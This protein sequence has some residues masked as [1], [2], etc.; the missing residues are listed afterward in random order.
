MSLSPVYGARCLKTKMAA[1]C[2]PDDQT[3]KLGTGNSLVHFLYLKYWSTVNKSA[4]FRS[5]LFFFFAVFKVVH[6]RIWG[7]HFSMKDVDRGCIGT[8]N[9]SVC[10]RKLFF[11]CFR[12]G[13]CQTLIK[14]GAYYCYCAYVLRISRHS[15]FLSVM[16]TNIAIFLRGLK[17]YGKSRP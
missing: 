7:L 17:L 1:V 14:D 9:Y 16:L 12:R 3:G 2:A 11:A 6:K 13:Y 8:F 4:I 10:A 15:D 5:Y